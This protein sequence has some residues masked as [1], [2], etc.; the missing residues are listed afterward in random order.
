M[1]LRKILF[2]GIPGS[3]KGTQ[4]KLLVPYNLKYIG[5]G[6]LIREA[7]ERKDV[8]IIPYK[9]GI[10]KGGLLPDR[11]TFELIDR[12]VE[13]LG[14]ADGYIFDGAI[15]N[16]A[17]AG[18]ALQRNLLGEVLFLELSE[19][20]AIKRLSKRQEHEGREDDSPESIL[21][22]IGIYRSQTEPVI[23]YLKGED[24]LI[25]TINAFSSVGDVHKEVL[26]V[27]KLNK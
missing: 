13:N 20:R 27:L 10:G 9:T 1:S 12:E 22:R 17:Q 19:K 26:G 16:L 3:G 24:I 7:L 15:R 23:D 4:A 14:E 8:L 18:I 25:H 6:E 21:K 5:T 2:I 11:E